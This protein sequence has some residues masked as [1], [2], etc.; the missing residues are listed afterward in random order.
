MSRAVMIDIETLGKRAGCVIV[1]IGAVIFDPNSDWVGESLHT[2][3]DVD[4]SHLRGFKTDIDTVFW[5]LGQPDEARASLRA[6]QDS[7]VSVYAA[8]DGLCNFIAGAG[9]EPGIW[10][11]GAS[12]DFPILY[13]YFDH[14]NLPLPW[15][16]WQERDLRTLKGLNKGLRIARQGTHHDALDDALHQA[17]LVQHI[18][19]ANPDM[20]A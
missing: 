18:L 9:D 6:G 19:Q 17:R 13:A 3:I 12:F 1:S 8:L 16:F 7:A 4:D 14:F 15:N 20:D 5:W 11:N 10:C 2:H